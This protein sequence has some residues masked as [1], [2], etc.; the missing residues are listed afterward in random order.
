MTRPGR[1]WVQHKC[2]LLGQNC[3]H[4]LG[5][6]K[7]LHELYTYGQDGQGGVISHDPATNKTKVDPKY[8]D[9]VEMLEEISSLVIMLQDIIKRFKQ[10][11]V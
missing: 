10:E 8:P 6:L 2:D 5:H 7:Q 11:R 4:M 3:D 1:N 9:H